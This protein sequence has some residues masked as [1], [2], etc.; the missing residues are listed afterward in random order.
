MQTRLLSLLE[1][2]AT[3]IKAKVL[4]GRFQA[5]VFLLVMRQ[6][7]KTMLALDMAALFLTAQTIK[8]YLTSLQALTVETTSKD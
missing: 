6:S 7:S 1:M 4:L 3:A 8:L 5:P 2:G